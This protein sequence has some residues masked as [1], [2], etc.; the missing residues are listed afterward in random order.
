MKKEE[1]VFLEVM[2]NTPRYRVWDFL[3]TFREVDY[4]KTQVAECTETSKV[5]VFTV[6]NELV[7]FNIIKKTR[8]IGKGQ[9]FKLN[10]EN[11]IVQNMIRVY[12]CILKQTLEQGEKVAQ[13]IPV[14]GYR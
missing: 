6:W 4:T 12:D 5:A 14:R 11:P 10:I 1:S 13:P 3:L 7:K 8:S 2:G 9:Y